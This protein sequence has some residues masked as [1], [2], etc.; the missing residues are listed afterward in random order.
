VAEVTARELGVVELSE[1]LDLICL[2]AEKTPERLDAFARRFV[3]RL[4]DER[5][6][7][8]PELDLAVTAL[9]ALPSQ[10][11]ANALRALL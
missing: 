3:A 2:V 7:K 9:R 10:R 5:A 1:A 6:L 8:L 4:A 11:A